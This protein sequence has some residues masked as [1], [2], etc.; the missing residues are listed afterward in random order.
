LRIRRD[1]VFVSSVLFTIAFVCL[2]PVSWRAAQIKQEP[3][4]QGAGFACL[5]NIFVGLVVT[6]MGLNKRIRWSWLVMFI[7]V[8]VGAFPAIVLPLLQHTLATKLTEW[9]YGALRE[10]GMARTW[11]ESVLIFILMVIALILPVKA[12]LGKRS[13]RQANDHWSNE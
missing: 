7:I 6:W 10:P 9:V 5:A 4:L 8:W 2:I 13:T 3:L 12:L 11:A 1:V